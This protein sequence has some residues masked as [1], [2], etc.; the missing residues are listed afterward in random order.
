VFTVGAVSGSAN[1]PLAYQWSFNGANLTNGAYVSGAT[2][3]ALTISNLSAA[4]AG[5]YTVAVS[6]ALGAILAGARLSIANT[7]APALLGAQSFGLSEVVV[8]LSQRLSPSSAQSTSNYFI[9]GAEGAVTILS[10]LLDSS[11]SNVWL[12]V[13]PMVDGELYTLSVS[14]VANAFYPASTIA[15]DAHTNF[16]AHSYIATGIGNPP[17]GGGQVWLTN[18]VAVT[19]VGT[20]I[21]GTSDQFEFS[22]RVLLGNFHVSVCLQSLDPSDVWAKAGLMAR[23]SLEAGSPFAASLATP[24]LAGDLFEYRVSTNST[25]LIAGRFPA[26]YPNTWLRLQRSGNVFSGYASYDGQSW[27][28]LA[29]ASIPMPSQ[30]Y[31]GMAVCS[32]STSR[33]ATAQFLLPI[34]TPAGASVSAVASPYEPLGPSS[35]K[36]GIVIPEIIY[37]P[38]SRADGLNLEFIELYSIWPET[39]DF[40]SGAR[41]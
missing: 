30:V 4:S 32:H 38:A 35:R 20:D 11:Q 12:T 14:N 26:N 25:A 36:T 23:A 7:D 33:A 27:V 2:S 5:L 24:S 17:S 31:L 15:P 6:N 39:P 28:L 34:D 1:N 22:Y 16:V 29:Q 37:K 18:V 19:G 13:S 3:P 41:H 9:F 10:A 40:G 21:G 8:S